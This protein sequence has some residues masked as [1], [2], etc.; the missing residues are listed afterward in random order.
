M[1]WVIKKVAF[2]MKLLVNVDL[3][4]CTLVFE[5]PHGLLFLSLYNYAVR[6]SHLIK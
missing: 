1:K 5:Q 4:S 2:V 6:W 3:L